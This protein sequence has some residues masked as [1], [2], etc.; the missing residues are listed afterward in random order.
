MT[1]NSQA[2]ATSAQANSTGMRTAIVQKWS[3]FTRQDVS[4]LKNEGDFV[5]QVQFKYQLDRLQAQKDVNAFFKG[6]QL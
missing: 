2:T 3:K 5:T 6:R 1:E 4:A